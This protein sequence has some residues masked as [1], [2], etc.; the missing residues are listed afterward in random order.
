MR[1]DHRFTWAEGHAFADVIQTGLTWEADRKTFDPRIVILNP[2]DLAVGD[3]RVDTEPALRF[4][5]RQIKA[6]FGVD[7]TVTPDTG[8]LDLLAVVAASCPD[9]F[10][11]AKAHLDRIRAEGEAIDLVARTDLPWRTRER[12][13]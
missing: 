2:E 4:A 1:T 11:K 6:L 3:I 7:V 12:S 10:E 8:F 9:W 13:G 5:E